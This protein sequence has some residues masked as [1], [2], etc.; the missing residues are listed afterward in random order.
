VLLSR[1][2]ESLDGDD[3]H[4]A[5]DF[6]RCWWRSPEGVPPT[7]DLTDE[8]WAVYRRLLDDVYTE[9]WDL[10]QDQPTLIITLDLYNPSLQLQRDSGI[11]EACVAW[12]ES[13]RAQLDQAAEAHGSVFLSLQD[14]FNGAD[15]Q[16][17]PAEAGLIGP[18]EADP[19]APWYRSTPLGASEHAAAL[20]TASLEALN[21]P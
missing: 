16:L 7:S 15:H 21:A 10:R 9:L 11:D 13:W 2:G 19:S 5:E 6:R 17:D 3:K 4:A 1:P 20:V 14:V 12:F 18:T 8:Y